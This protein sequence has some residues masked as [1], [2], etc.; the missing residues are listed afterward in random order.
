MNVLMVSS[1]ADFGGGQEHMFQLAKRLLSKSTLNIFVAI[2]QEEPY[3]NRFKLLLGEDALVEIPHRGVSL[4]SL[5][6]LISFCKKKEISFMHSHGKGAGVVSRLACLA[7]RL[8]SVHTPHGIHTDQYGPFKRRLYVL[9]E[10]ISARLV[11]CVCFVSESE[12]EVAS[13]TGLWKKVSALVIPNGVPSVDLPPPQRD[14]LIRSKLDIGSDTFVVVTISRFDF[15]KNMRDAY[16]VARHLPSMHFIWVG[17]GEEKEGLERKAAEEG[18]SN[19]TFV[20]FSGDP[21]RYLSCSDAY[22]STSRWEGMP[23]SILEAM[24]VG[25]PIVASDVVGNKDVVLNDK[26]GFLFSAGDVRQAVL[27]LKTLQSNRSIR[28]KF[29]EKSL[30]LQRD[31][32]SV[33]AMSAKVLDVY[34]SVK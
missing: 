24:S 9:Y 5:R 19:I 13:K 27:S 15:Q 16:R 8:R 28:M 26:N 2:P 11:D 33:E 25:L 31:L 10:N 14:A 4:S 29:S 20:G 18:L 21:L 3:W 1:R 17:D 12:R 34:R 7:L 32:Y 30:L 23:L 22:L 6:K